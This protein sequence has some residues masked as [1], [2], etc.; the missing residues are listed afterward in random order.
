MG[1]AE[2]PSSQLLHLVWDVWT[3]AC[4]TLAAQGT[5]CG[6]HMA[7][8]AGTW[9]LNPEPHAAGRGP[10]AAWALTTACRWPLRTSGLRW[11]GW[12]DEREPVLLTWIQQGYATSASTVPALVLMP[13]LN[14]F[15][16]QLRCSCCCAAACSAQRMHTCEERLGFHS[17]AS[18]VYDCVCPGPACLPQVLSK[19]DDWSW[20]MGNIVH[21]MTNRR[22]AEACVVSGRRVELCCKDLCA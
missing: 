6:G 18:C 12:P 1:R 4:A 22:Y 15:V 5:G 10:R 14:R 11:A 16:C 17:D 19:H 20:N 2:Q 13:L 21:T 8:T 9:P 3:L 7:L